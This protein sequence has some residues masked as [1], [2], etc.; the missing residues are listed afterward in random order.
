MRPTQLPLLLLTLSKH[1]GHVPSQNRHQDKGP[2][3]WVPGQGA[4]DL[5]IP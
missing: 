2:G 4:Y 1:P 5:Q 3:G